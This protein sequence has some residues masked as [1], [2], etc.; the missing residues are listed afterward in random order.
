[1]RWARQLL[2]FSSTTYAH[3]SHRFALAP[4]SAFAASIVGGGITVLESLGSV[5]AGLS[6]RPIGEIELLL[7]RYGWAGDLG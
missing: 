7:R 2:Y 6:P 4:N 1:M 3:S 5:E